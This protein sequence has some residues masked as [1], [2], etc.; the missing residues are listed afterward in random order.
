M[1][2]KKEE[3]RIQVQF[4]FPTNDWECITPYLN[5]YNPWQKCQTRSIFLSKLLYMDSGKLW[6]KVMHKIVF[7]ALLI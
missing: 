3:G 6:H 7:W 4:G 5:P 1:K 2:N